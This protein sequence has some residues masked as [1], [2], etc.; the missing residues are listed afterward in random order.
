MPRSLVACLLYGAT[1]A[2]PIHTAIAQNAI[3]E[4]LVRS[5]SL[6][7]TIPLELSR[8]GNRL[9]IVT[10]EDLAQHAFVDVSQALQMLVPGLH[11]AP[12]NGAFDYFDASLQGSRTQEILWLIDGVR[13][14]NRLYNGTSPLD[15]VPA[16]MIERIEVLKGGQGIFYGTQSVGGVVNVVTRGFQQALGGEVG[17]GA[18]SNE[19]SNV[20]ALVRGGSG[21]Q[22]FVLYGSRDEAQGYLPYRREDLQP[23]ATDRERGYEVA[24]LGGKYALDISERSRLSLQYQR[25]ENTLDFLTAFANRKT[26]NAR[27]ED[28][29]TLKYDLQLGERLGLYVK[30][31]RHD[32]DTRYTR[33]H[34]VVNAAG[35][36]TGALRVRDD[37][38]F[39][40]YEDSG[41]NAV[42]Q[43]AATD[44]VDVLLGVD[45]Q[46]FSGSD[47]VW[48]IAD[49]EEKVDA[50]FAQVRSTDALFQNTALALGVRHNRADNSA[51]ATVWN[52]SG[53]HDV[54]QTLFVRATLGTSF[55]LP[56]AESLFLNEYYDDDAD[57]V[58]DGGWFAL[59]NSALK[60]ERSRNLNLGLGGKWGAADWELVGYTRR[61]S[62]YIAAYV[63]LVIAGVEGE[64]FSNSRDT[65]EVEGVELIATLPLGRDWHS[66]VA[67]SHTRAQLNGSGAQLVGIPRREAK[68]QTQYAP[69]GR[70][71][72]LALALNHVGEITA[73]RG[74]TRGHY[75]VSDLSGSYA[76]G[77]G[78]EHRLVLKLENLTD[79]V[80]TTR[81]DTGTLDS[82]GAYLYRA[83]G[84]PR[85]LHLHY[86]WQF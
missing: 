47:D 32:W 19:G 27:E 56:D 13:I 17:V 34:N 30:G 83:I 2:A 25:T 11:I 53:Q 10:A 16:H 77:P 52:V 12:K 9:E 3:E 42:L 78:G 14:T 76:F 60:P 69:A 67:L 39:W 15:T 36:L 73:R 61:I 35:A 55:R 51:S 58:P 24:V 59:G 70:P 62:D 57:G 72:S 7:D 81:V 64:S 50:V 4:I 41:V 85:T 79:K 38:S 48:R 29:L 86:S 37:K 6:E 68:W 28:I 5:S 49:L 74:Q 45:T 33:I 44:R 43:Y 71:W 66:S 54:S 20:N 21:A 1:L 18:H 65:V 31:Y 22:Q 75:T 84:T 46:R 63:P 8:F 80:Y 23:S 26:F 82:G 40:G